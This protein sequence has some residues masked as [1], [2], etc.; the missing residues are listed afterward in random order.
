VSVVVLMVQMYR[1]K[2]PVALHKGELHY[3]LPDRAH[4]KPLLF[5]GLPMSISMVVMG[6]SQLIVISLINREGMQTVA[7]FGAVNNL[8]TYL[9]MPAFAVATAVSAMAAQ[10]I[11]A[12]RWDRVGQVAK[13]GALINV[14][15]TC[16]VL[17]VMILAIRPLLGLFLPAGSKAI[18]I[19]AH[20]NL[21]VGWTYV[22]NS[23]ASVLTSVIRANGETMA[24][25][26]IMVISGVVI[27]FAIAFPLYPVWGDDAIWASFAAAA[28]SGAAMGLAY[29]RWGKWR[30]KKPMQ[31]MV[32]DPI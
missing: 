7:G 14:A 25:L 13:A 8:W 29:Y 4:F 1:R 20:I 9:Q 28:L 23:I 18:E 24:P 16:I 32:P 3:C 27:R 2:A 10:N 5:M 31:G 21:L 26:W 17:A 19:G 22:V 12:N 11:G 30:D 6:L 15:M